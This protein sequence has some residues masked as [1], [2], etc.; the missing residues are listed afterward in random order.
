MSDSSLTAPVEIELTQEERGRILHDAAL[1]RSIADSLS[2]KRKSGPDWWGILNGALPLLIISTVLTLYI[3]PN[4]QKSERRRDLQQQLEIEQG[5][6]RLQAMRESLTKF[7][8][9]TV[10]SVLM[11]D[12]VSELQDLDNVPASEFNRLRLRAQSLMRQRFDANAGFLGSLVFYR[13]RD[14]L[15]AAADAYSDS[16]INLLAEIEVYADFRQKHPKT[17]D[18]KDEERQTLENHVKKFNEHFRSVSEAREECLRQVQTQVDSE[19]QALMS[20][21]R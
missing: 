14:R 7:M 10:V 6:I 3:I 16:T 19:E 12:V 2:T 8:R 13:E 9:V 1:V 5:K 11:L 15:R 17:E 20:P 18:M 4:S 21:D